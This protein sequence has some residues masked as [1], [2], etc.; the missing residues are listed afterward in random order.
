MA[1]ETEA[2]QAPS[3]PQPLPLVSPEW[4]KAFTDSSAKLYGGFYKEAAKFMS[5][6][7]EEQTDYLR[8]LA[9]CDDPMKLMN[10]NSQFIMR[11]FTNCTED[12]KAAF[13]ALQHSYGWSSSS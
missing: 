5:R 2:T 12:A 11:S 13:A 3:A 7:L 9:K 6:R 1:T 4:S 8:A 10:C